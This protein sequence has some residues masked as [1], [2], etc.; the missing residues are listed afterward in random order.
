VL[1]QLT[2]PN[3]HSG[4][5]LSLHQR[6]IEV[7]REKQKL[8]ETK[9]VE[10]SRAGAEN[11]AIVNKLQAWHRD[12]LKE[13]TAERLPQIVSNGLA[14]M[15]SIPTVKL[16]IWAD[17]SVAVADGYAL[18]P[19]PED[20]QHIDDRHS[21]YCGPAEGVRLEPWLGRDHKTRSLVFIP[22]RVGAAPKSFGLLILGS[23]DADRYT[24]GMG[25]DFLNAI[26]ESAS[27]SL[28]RLLG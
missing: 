1:G 9:V 17:D 22:L 13:K 20:R 7:L 6:Q 21:I 8:L 10:M 11:Q 24:P 25:M 3:Q 27:A 15:F 28:S 12:L 4:K 16:A 18:K 2:L 23:P 5:A 14:A 26:A 19:A